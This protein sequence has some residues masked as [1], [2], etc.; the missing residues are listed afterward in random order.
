MKNI[1]YRYLLS[2]SVIFILATITTIPVQAKET[3]AE[4]CQ[5]RQRETYAKTLSELQADGNLTQEAIDALGGT[6][7][8]P[9]KVTKKSN[10]TTTGSASASNEARGWVYSTDELHITGL[11]EDERGYTAAGDYGVIPQ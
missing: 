4:R 10:Q 11:P 1:V 3:F 8:K 2:I 7:M 9:N 6:G 5:R